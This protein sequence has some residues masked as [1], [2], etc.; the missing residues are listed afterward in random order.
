VDAAAEQI[1]TSPPDQNAEASP[2]SIWGLKEIL[3][4]HADWLDSNGSAGF[5]ADFSRENLSGTDLIDAKLRGAIFDKA[6]LKRA[7]LMMADLSD[8]SLLQ[9][10]LSDANLLGTEFHQANLQ[11]AH[12]DGAT[13]LLGPQLAGANLFGAVLPAETAPLEGMKNVGEVASRAGWFLGFVLILSAA[14]WLRIFTTHDAE[15]LTNAGALPFL[16]L[17]AEFPFIPFYLFAPVALLSVYV[18]FHL[19]LQRLWD[20]AAQLPAIFPDGRSLDACLP[21]FARWSARNHFKWL[22]TKRSPL[23]FLETGLAMFMLYWVVP[24]TAVLFWGRYLT[25]Q[26][27]R[28][29]LLHVLLIGG[30]V[31]AGLNFPRMVGKAFRADSSQPSTE[32]KAGDWRSWELRTVLPVGVSALLLILSMGVKFGAPHGYGRNTGTSGI[33]I[34]SWAANLLWTFG[35]N[36]YAQLAETDVSKRPPSW[37]GAISSEKKGDDL[38]LVKGA[39]LNRIKLR[40]A[41]AYGAF[42]LGAHLWQA[43]LRNGYLPES[44]LR[45]AN[46]RDADL[47]YAV[48]DHALVSGAS[49]QEADLRNANFNRADLQGANLSTAVASN[50]TLLDAILDRATLYKVDLRS[51]SLQRSSWK[52]ADLREADLENANLTMANL[53]EAYLTSTKLANAHLNRADLSLAILT[54]ADLKHSDLSGSDFRGAILRGADLTGANLQDANLTGAVGVS[55]SQICSAANSG[56]AQMDD[57]L[58]MEVQALCGNSRPQIAVP[59]PPVKS[60]LP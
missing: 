52:Q 47:R 51:A 15:L 16:G 6:S 10:N 19:Y 29:S 14:A 8:A 37:A 43:D 38:A 12:L 1:K 7:D 41:Q 49:L 32:Q 39:N 25:L 42:L 36:P 9:A 18:C 58:Q 50:A 24:A 21:W 13:G 54:D 34:S 28:G 5:Q 11:A 30:A 53:Q 22:K 20:G 26:D 40:Y 33:G 55:A 44:D 4:Q 57:N 59:P 23:A 17:Q 45:L 56:K 46:L 3:Q 31:A 48:L 2:I 35:Y 60:S 27:I